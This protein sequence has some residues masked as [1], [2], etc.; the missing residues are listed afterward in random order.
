MQK[1]KLLLPLISGIIIL[2]LS[3]CKKNNTIA[4]EIETT[5][6]LTGKQAI[7]ES[8]TDDANNL[9]DETTET[10][11]LSGNKAPIIDNGTLSCATVTVSPGAFPKTITLDFGTGCTNPNSNIERSGIVHIV[12]SDSF[13]LTGSTAIMTFD[14][15]YVNGYK[16]EGTI[17]WTNTS[18]ATVRSWSRQVV[19]GKITAPDG[20]FWFHN[21]LKQ[22]TQVAGNNTPRILLDDAFSITGSSVITNSLG[23]TRTATIEIPLHKRVDCD[24]VDEGSIRFQGPN[25]FATLDFGNGTCDAI[26]TISINNYQPRT[27]TLP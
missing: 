12:L 15:Y 3:S 6:D 27:I 13:R 17:T 2:G 14:N 22:I 8:L 5:F 19:N 16:K 18:T 1:I 11:G 26:A 20:R 21:G 25:H 9:L 10:L 23:D 4:S 7:S 24:H